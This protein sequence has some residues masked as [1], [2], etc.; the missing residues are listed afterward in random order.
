MGR[1]GVLTASSF[2][3]AGGSYP[4]QRQIQQM[5][6]PIIFGETVA[7]VRQ[8]AVVEPGVV[9][10]QAEGVLEVDPAP[11]RLGGLPVRQ[12]EQ[13]LQHAHGGQLSRGQPGTTITRVPA[14]EVLIAPQAIQVVTHPHRRRTCRAARV[15]HPR[16]QLRDLIRP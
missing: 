16:G 10:L 11:H 2:Q 15:R 13:E 3:Q 9:Q 5:V 6:G 8:N 14:G 4:L 1:V 7:E 12:V